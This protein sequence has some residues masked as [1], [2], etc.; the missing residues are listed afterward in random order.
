LSASAL[1]YKKSQIILEEALPGRWLISPMLYPSPSDDCAFVLAI[2]H[3]GQAEDQRLVYHKSPWH[4]FVSVDLRQLQ[5]NRILGWDE[6]NGI[7]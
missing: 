6:A 4:K 3:T 5:V 1:I 2:S 7:T